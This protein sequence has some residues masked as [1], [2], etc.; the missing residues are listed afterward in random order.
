MN[1]IYL[2]LKPIYEH[3]AVANK[4]PK[5]YIRRFKRRANGCY[6]WKVGKIVICTKNIFRFGANINR[7]IDHEVMHYILDKF[8]GPVA[9]TKWDNIY[10]KLD[11]YMWGENNR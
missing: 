2:S 9:R 11:P 10:D 7:I 5:A 4:S 6:C 8:I 3:F 1:D